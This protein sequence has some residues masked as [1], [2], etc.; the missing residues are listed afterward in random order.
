MN[1]ESFKPI[2]VLHTLATYPFFGALKAVETDLRLGQQWDE[3]KIHML[4]MYSEKE[5]P[6]L[7]GIP[8]TGLLQKKLQYVFPV[9]LQETISIKTLTAIFDSMKKQNL[10]L[11]QDE[12]GLSG[13]ESYIYLGIVC[14]DSTVVYYKVTDGLMKPRQNDEN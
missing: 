1:K 8:K 12:R 11:V 4:K 13:K 10:L 6:L 5:R 3:L 9:L 7:S 14:S 2:E